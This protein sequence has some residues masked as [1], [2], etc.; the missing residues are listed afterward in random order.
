MNAIANKIILITGA[1][2]GIGEAC[3]HI[4]AQHQAK[5][6][7]CARRQEKIEKLAG[8]LRDKYNV[9]IYCIKTDVSSASAVG[10]SISNLPTAWKNIDILINNAGLALGFD[11]FQNGNVNDWNQMIDTNF[12]GL[13]YVTH[14]VLPQMIER[15][16][17]HIINI[18]S[19]AGHEAYTNGNVYCA[20]KFAVNGFTKCLK[21]D[22]QGTN[23]RVTSV[24]PGAVETDFSKVRFKGNEARAAQ[25]YQ[26]F[27][28]LTPEDIADSVYYCASRP[29]HVNIREMIIM[30]TAQA[31]SSMIFKE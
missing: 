20:T 13:L 1:S 10:D 6:I 21:M 30:P 31:S 15:N 5:I 7:L 11:K 4:F 22:L 3:A 25:V 16:Q 27:V 14:A 29:A 12:K 24:D 18:G 8:H 23:I 28:P 2:G 9:E 19:I 17:G 26:G